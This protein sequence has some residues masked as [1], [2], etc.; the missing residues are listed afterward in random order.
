M[1]YLHVSSDQNLVL[2]E[3]PM[4]VIAKDECLIRVHAIGINRADL[5]QKAGQYPAPKGESDILGLEVAGD[6]IDC[7]A[8]CTDWNKGDKVF[9]LVAGGGYA[10]YVVIKQGQLFLLP[11][12]YT[13]EQGAAT[14]EVFL[15]AY[16]SLFTIAQLKAKASVLIHAGAS[17]V[18][19][20]AI[21][22]AKSLGCY[23][24]T[25]VS[26]KE[27]QKAC[28][29]LG[30]NHVINYKETDFV[31]W[32]K[33]NYPQGFDVIIDVVAGT[34]LNKNISVANI[35]CH[36]VV[37]AML[38]GRYSDPIDFVKMLSNRITISASTLRNRS[39]QYKN[40]LVASLKRDFENKFNNHTIEPVIYKSFSWEDANEAHKVMATNENIGKLILLIK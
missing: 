34:Q 18:G 7:G 33:D 38:G 1:K 26:T 11:P 17:G 19:T 13:Y 35:D 14:A 15:T 12:T 31:D 9:G 36:I 2:C 40:T 30:A 32:T 5:L 21:Q 4:P 28:L 10:E 23:V 6:I 37:L 16:Q 22:L 20:A 3:T 24:V 39:H 8:E 25:T 29:D 27:K